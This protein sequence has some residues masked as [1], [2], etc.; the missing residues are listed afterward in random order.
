[1]LEPLL[2]PSRGL[3]ESDAAP[4]CLVA[5]VVRLDGSLAVGRCTADGQHLDLFRF[6]ARRGALETIE[7]AKAI[8]T[9]STLATAMEWLSIAL[10][11]QLLCVGFSHGGVSLFTPRGEVFL[12]FLLVPKA[13]LRLRVDAAPPPQRGQQ[14]AAQQSQLLILHERGSIAVVAFGHLRAA[15]LGGPSAEGSAVEGGGFRFQLYELRG[16]EATSDVCL[17]NKATSLDDVFATES[18]AA[19]VALGSKPFLSLHRAQLERA[20]GRSLIGSAASALGAYARSWVPFRGR[21]GFDPLTAPP[22]RSAG[23][24]RPGDIQVPPRGKPEELA[25]DAKFIDPARVGDFL[26]LAPPRRR[27]AS[28]LAA[29]CDAYGRVSVFCLES[30]RCLHMWKGYRDAHVAWLPRSPTGFSDGAALVIYAPR[31]GLLELWDIAGLAGPRRLDA[32]AVSAD[33][34]L[35]STGGQVHLLQR[36]GA[37]DRIHWRAGAARAASPPRPPPAFAASAEVG[38]VTERGGGS[39][40]SSDDFGSVGSGAEGGAEGDAEGGA[41]SCVI[42]RP[43]A[44]T[45]EKRE[46]RDVL[47]EL[48]ERLGGAAL[49]SMASDCDTTVDALGAVASAASAAE[50]QWREVSLVDLLQELRSASA[51][52]QAAACVLRAH[53]RCNEE[54][55]KAFTAART[56]ATASRAVLATGARQAKHASGENEEKEESSDS[57]DCDDVPDEPESEEDKAK[58][59]SIGKAILVPTEITLAALC[60]VLEALPTLDGMVP[61]DGC[62]RDRLGAERENVSVYLALLQLALFTP[63]GCLARDLDVGKSL[64]ATPLGRGLSQQAKQLAKDALPGKIE[65]TGEGDIVSDCVLGF[66]GWLAGHLERTSASLLW[67]T[68]SAVGL[69]PAVI[70]ALHLYTPASCDS[71]DGVASR[72]LP[73]V[74]AYRDFAARG[75]TPKVLLRFVFQSY[76]LDPCGACPLVVRAARALRWQALDV[77]WDRRGCAEDSVESA[78]AE[79]CLEWLGGLPLSPLL[80]TVAVSSSTPNSTHCGGNLSVALR[81]LFA[82]RPHMLLSFIGHAAPHFLPCLALVVHVLATPPPPAGEVEGVLARLAHATCADS[83]YEGP[84]VLRPGDLWPLLDAQLRLWLRLVCAVRSPSSLQSG[85]EAATDA[86]AS[87]PPQRGRAVASRVSPYPDASVHRLLFA[88]PA[89]LACHALAEGSIASGDAM[90]TQGAQQGAQA[91]SADGQGRVARA[92]ALGIGCHPLRALAKLADAPGP[93]LAA[94]P[95]PEARSWGS[96]P[97]ASSAVVVIE[98]PAAPAGDQDVQEVAPPRY[99]SGALL[100]RRVA[101][102]LAVATAAAGGAGVT[103]SCTIDAPA[104]TL[105]PQPRPVLPLSWAVECNCAL[106]LLWRAHGCGSGACGAPEL[107]RSAVE[108]VAGLRLGVVRNSLAWFAFS[109]AFLDSVG[110]WL[111]AVAAGPPHIAFSV[112]GAELE[113][114][115]ALLNLATAAT[116]PPHIE[117]TA[118]G[119]GTLDLSWAEAEAWALHRDRATSGNFVVLLSPASPVDWAGDLAARAILQAAAG[120]GPARRQPTLQAAALMLQAV[121]AARGANIAWQ[122]APLFPGAGAALARLAEGADAWEEDL[123]DFQGAETR[124]PRL[125]FLLALDAAGSRSREAAEGLATTFG[126]CEDLHAVLLRHALLRGC[127]HEADVH[128]DR[129]RDN[130]EVVSDL[131]AEALRHRLAASLQVLCNDEAAEHAMVLCAVGPELLDGLLSLAVDEATTRFAAADVLAALRSCG[132]LAAHPLLQERPPHFQEAAQIAASLLRMMAAGPP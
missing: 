73:E 86:G 92:H 128:L 121:Q 11:Q 49:A 70:E 56:S 7:A 91:N 94:V 20:D 39:E 115:I 130:P 18:A 125:E 119:D 96:A 127:D 45:Q 67:S 34:R 122:L 75:S 110:S 72:L 40:P 107:L 14:A 12:S 8:A 132:A 47:A 90:F 114:A 42:T 103:P 117:A 129:L 13:I 33:G 15:V 99:A 78:C 81:A 124:G 32:A 69:Q 51:I 54:L 77:P 22:Q 53:L 24:M 21:P 25:L 113:A 10:D 89:V 1:M 2:P 93:W 79:R 126:L 9:G 111:A 59:E 61:E 84:A 35:L 5:A 38:V 68:L 105:L 27:G 30:L 57:D 82:R 17:V 83:D 64:A 101:T 66:Q 108:R 104:L 43:V 74:L 26:L 97:P 63:S 98:T 112:D 62:M 100:C 116:R 16:R 23:S 3:D 41:E 106:L 88:W 109:C 46:E 52:D 31:R 71:A 19:F 120:D 123:A 44:A 95:V 102:A 6:C 85:G 60:K 37:L 48:Q 36:S 4:A 58:R 80:R 131:V 50:R 76:F 55:L 87:E 65:G 29:A 118:S 28:T